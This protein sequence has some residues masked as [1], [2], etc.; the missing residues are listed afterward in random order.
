MPANNKYMKCL[1]IPESVLEQNPIWMDIKQKLQTNNKQYRSLS[2]SDCDSFL[3]F[4]ETNKAF[5]ERY[6]ADGIEENPEYQQFIFYCVVRKG[7]SFFVYQRGGKNEGAQET[8]LTMKMSAGVGGHIE[9]FDEKIAD[10]LYREF[11]EELILKKNGVPVPLRSAERILNKEMMRE[12]MTVNVIGLLKEE[13]GGIG[14]VHAGLV[15]EV[16]LSDDS[17]DVAIREHEGNVYGLFMTREAYDAQVSSGKFDPENW[18]QIL[19]NFEV[20]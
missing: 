10:S 4:I 13:T 16:V 2:Q 15:T 11:D 3:E 5:Y 12:Y 14:M 7:N 9:S 19:R 6:G 1:A 8:R 20:I 17:L 18:T